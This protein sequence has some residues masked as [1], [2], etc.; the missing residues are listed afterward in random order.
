MKRNL[1]NFLLLSTIIF[2]PFFAQDIFACQCF[3]LPTPYE[4][5]KEANAVFTGRVVSVTDESGKEVVKKKMSDSEDYNREREEGKRFYR[6]DVQEW[7][8]GEK[9]SEITISH[10]VNMCEFSFDVGDEFLVYAYE[11]NGEL[12]TS[13]FC[14]RTRSLENA[15]K[16]DIYFLR[17]LLKGIPEP[18]IYGSVLLEDKDPITNSF[19]S[20]FLER[21]KVIAQRNKRQYITFTDK[22]GLYRFNKLPNGKYVVSMDLPNKYKEGDTWDRLFEI[23]LQSNSDTYQQEY[24]KFSGANAYSN[25]RLRWNNRI[26]GKILDSEGKFLK[27]GSFKFIPINQIDKITEEPFLRYKHLVDYLFK[28]NEKSVDRKYIETGLTPGK[29]ILAIEIFAPFI[30]GIEKLRMYYPQASTPQTAEII[31]IGEFDNRTIDVKLPSE[32]IIREIEGTLV[33]ENGD[34]IENEYASV[35]VKKKEN[36]DTTDNLTYDS[37]F[38]KD[39]KFK[40]QVFENAEYWLHAEVNNEKAKPIK[41]KIGKINQP[42]KIVIPSLK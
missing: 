39:G 16:D 7:F 8:K 21:I 9:D 18:R 30:S 11:S 25:L 4:A 32:Y 3:G 13:T 6:F 10:N 23:N 20:K 38:V 41:I 37:V 33:R 27:N 42:I 29:Y 31:N 19:R 40:L 15:K 5:F 35:S 14:W 28:E 34:I 26:S 24:N 1:L 36:S 12:R 2:L 17:E 22:N